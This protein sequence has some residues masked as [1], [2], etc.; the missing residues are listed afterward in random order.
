VIADGNRLIILDGK[1]GIEKKSR[2]LPEDNY[3]IVQVIG[4]PTD[5]NEAVIVIKNGEYGYGE[6]RYGEPVLGLNS[7]LEIVWGPKAIPGGGHHILAMDLNG[8][9]EKEYLIGYCAVNLKGEILWTV[10]A[11]DISLLNQKYGHVDYTDIT[12]RSD[13]LQLFAIAG[14]DKLYLAQEGGK[15]IFS[16]PGPHAQGSALGH[17]RSDSE[18]QVALYMLLMVLWFCMTPQES[19]YGIKQLRVNGL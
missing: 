8:D 4:E 6:W 17:F 5:E 2:S 7:N 9:G 18:F 3:S 1:T 14:S 15:T 11:I 10:N 12:R 19:R 16:F 13:G